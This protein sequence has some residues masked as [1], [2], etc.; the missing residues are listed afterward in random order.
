MPGIY[1]LNVPTGGGKTISVLRY[2][3]AHAKQYEKSRI[4]FIIPL[5][6]VLEQ[7][8][9]VIKDYMLDKHSVAEHHSNVVIMGIMRMS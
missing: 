5:L 7:N 6:S 8:S 3:L 9:G 2:S 4:I 1:Q